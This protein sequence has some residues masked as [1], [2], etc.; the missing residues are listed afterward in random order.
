MT[1]P[2]PVT[3]VIVAGGKSTRFGSDKASAVVAGRT[4]LEWVM[5]GVAPACEAVVVV[6]AKAQEL[7]AFAADVP[8]TV[9]EDLYEA[10]GP[11]AGL[12]AGFGAVS[13]PLAFAASC[14]VPL[15]RPAL[16]SGLAALAEGYDIVVPHVDGFPQPLLAVY[17]AGV[18]LPAFRQS[19]DE[20][21]LKITV[22]FAGLR[23]RPARESDLRALDPGLESFRNVNRSDDLGEIEAL[24]R[25]REGGA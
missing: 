10:K 22:A 17:R 13:T 24:L 2:E 6:R 7:P 5:R 19:V 12:V 25:A 15:V 11:L 18:C 4:L 16:V 21:R 20:D 23:V 3:G 8:V 14:D 1:T 9:V